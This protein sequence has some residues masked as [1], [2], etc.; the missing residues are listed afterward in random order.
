MLDSHSS[1]NIFRTDGNR[2]FV[3]FPVLSTILPF[4]E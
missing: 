1:K 3:K 4:L 2:M